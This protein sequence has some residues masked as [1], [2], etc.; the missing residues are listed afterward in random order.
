[1][2][3]SP[4]CPNYAAPFPSLVRALLAPTLLAVA[5]LAGCGTAEPSDPVGDAELAFLLNGERWTA[6]TEAQ[7]V[8]TDYG[9]VV[10]AELRFNDRFPYRQRIGFSVPAGEW[11][12][13]GTY[14][15]ARRSVNDLPYAAYVGELDGDAIIA[16]YD[17]TG[18][19][20]ERG[21]FEVTRYDGATGEVEG[22][23]EG[24]FV[25]DPSD[26]GQPLRELPDTLR[27]TEGRFRAVIEDRR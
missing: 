11:G 15:I 20:A 4:L 9:L 2:T 26:L 10:F 8:L 16:G 27:V 5:V 7:A 1:M 19:T 14:P 6:N 12:G 13:V 23:F 3:T 17:P 22:Q 18:P 24:T 25:V 21:G